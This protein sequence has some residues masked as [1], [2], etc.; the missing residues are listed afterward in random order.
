MTPVERSRLS[1][2]FGVLKNKAKKSDIPFEWDH[3]ADFVED[4]FDIAPADYTVDTYRLRFD[5]RRIKREDAGYCKDTLSVMK[6]AKSRYNK[7]KTKEL[8]SNPNLG[9]MSGEDA[10]KLSRVSAHLVLLIQELDGDVQLLT[11]LAAEAADS[12]ETYHNPHNQE[13]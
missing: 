1:N 10:A 8:Q 13:N 11:E 2:R 9:L 4:L 6:T 5:S 12:Y 3:F 7:T